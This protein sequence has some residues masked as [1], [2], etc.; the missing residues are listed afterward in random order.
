MALNFICPNCGYH[1]HFSEEFGEMVIETA[2]EYYGTTKWKALNVRSKNGVEGRVRRM[3]AYF[4]RN[5]TG[6]P[7]KNIG[8]FMGLSAN[9]A[10]KFYCDTE[11]LINEGGKYLQQSLELERL[12]LLR[13]KANK[14]LAG[15]EKQ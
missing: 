15:K 12:L 8:S 3:V 10:A 1:S 6:E 2:C 5:M 4:L 9:T 14:L 13:V 7:F 11:S